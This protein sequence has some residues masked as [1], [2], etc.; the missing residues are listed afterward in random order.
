MANI[1]SL[2]LEEVDKQVT[3]NKAGVYLLLRIDKKNKKYLVRYVGRS[4]SDLKVR[5]KQHCSEG[6]DAFWFE[7]VKSPLEAYLEECRL[8]HHYKGDIGLLDNEYHPDAPKGLAEKVVCP[9]C[10]EQ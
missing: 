7:Y 8:Y 10:I 1:F 2:T 4:D 5:L 9:Y 3:A 6:Y